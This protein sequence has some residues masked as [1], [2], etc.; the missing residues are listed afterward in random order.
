MWPLLWAGRT[1]LARAVHVPMCSSSA[2]F[3][4]AQ[5]PGL[6][7]PSFS[8]VFPCASKQ[9]IKKLKE[10]MSATEKVRREKWIEEKTKKIKEITVKGTGRFPQQ[11]LDPGQRQGAPRETGTS[12]LAW[13][14]FAP[15]FWWSRCQRTRK[16]LCA[17]A[18]LPAPFSQLRAPGWDPG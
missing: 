6:F 9:E 4:T 13:A 10:F 7:S 1:H 3:P 5:L 18:P 11:Q 17:H 8:E 15:C 16:P 12:A 14:V 2:S